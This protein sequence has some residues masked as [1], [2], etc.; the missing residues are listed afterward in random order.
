MLFRGYIIAPDMIQGVRGKTRED[1]IQ[2]KV[3]TNVDLG[4]NV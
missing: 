1:N 4:R 2:N 3:R